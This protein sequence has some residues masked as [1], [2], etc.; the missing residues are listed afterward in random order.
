LIVAPTSAGK[1]FVS[2][3]CIEKVLRQSNDG[4]VVYV[5]PS[6]ALI[7]QVCG[8][9]YARFRNKPLTGNKVLFGIMTG[10]YVDS[11]LNCQVLVTIPQCLE[12]ILISPEPR[13]QEFV[14]RIRYVILDEVHSINT[15]KQGHIWEH[16][17]L[18]IQSPFLA[19]SATIN[20]VD[21]MREWLQDAENSKGK[22]RPVKLI[23]YKERWSELELSMQK[24]KDC[25]DH[26]NFARDNDMF[27]KGIALGD[28]RSAE[29]SAAASLM[30]LN[31]EENLLHFFTPYSVYKPE[32]I[33]MFSIPDD[34][35]LTARQ[36]I[37]LYTI[38]SKVDEKTKKEF[39]PT[40]FFKAESVPDQKLWLTRSM[41]RELEGNL[42]VRFLEWLHHDEE[43]SKQVFQELEVD[44]KEDF[45]KRLRPFNM[46][47]LFFY[48]LIIALF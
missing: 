5:C 1:T 14:S 26:I 35:Q 21:E 19:L 37:E 7:N 24:L 9:I 40:K 32:K 31:Q 29:S 46:V 3:Y 43:K 38:M 42:R 11:P 18:L 8:S 28:V 17:F 15:A 39:E 25:P 10:E 6:K 48:R 4:V 13:I 45:E 33:R 12:H 20:N 44:V 30:S 27:Y 2:Y 41:L 22:G 47:S 36:V 23:Q 16:I 34:Q